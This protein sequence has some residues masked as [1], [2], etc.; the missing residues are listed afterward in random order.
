MHD[1]DAIG[2]LLGNANADQLAAWQAYGERLGLAFQWRDDLRGTF[3][4]PSAT[5]KPTW[6]D[7]RAGKN[8]SLIAAARTRLNEDDNKF[9]QW[10]LG[11]P[12]SEID[13]VSKAVSLLETCGARAEIEARI[14]A[15]L[16]QAKSVLALAPLSTE[17]TALL[18]ELADML[19]AR[20][21]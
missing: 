14:D 20:N 16:S 18:R 17:G 4:D 9:L 13:Q 21:A 10:V 15:L 11:N 6:N 7:I 3:G 8:T 12:E 19:G 1:R 5:G 2:A